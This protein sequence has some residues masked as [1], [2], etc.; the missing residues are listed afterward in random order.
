MP[1]Y[2][3]SQHDGMYPYS[4]LAM[5]GVWYGVHEVAQL[6][7][8]VQWC[9]HAVRG[10]A[11]A[12]IVRARAAVAQQHAQ[13]AAAALLLGQHLVLVDDEWQVVEQRAH[14]AAQDGRVV[15]LRI[16]QEA[17]SGNQ[18]TILIR[19][20]ALTCASILRRPMPWCESDAPKPRA[21]SDGR[22]S[23]VSRV[24]NGIVVT[25][26]VMTKLEVLPLIMVDFPPSRVD[27]HPIRGPI[28][29][30]A[31]PVS[32]SPCTVDESSAWERVPRPFR[33]DHPRRSR[34]PGALSLAAVFY[35]SASK[36]AC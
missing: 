25:L 24:R 9:A 28:C 15:S 35:R 5:Y 31:V 22:S 23:T 33:S 36:M 17:I 4:H 3:I 1:G 20:V 16:N 2:N 18:V 11:S 14:R 6:R 29:C 27:F 19:Q 26:G 13:E 7:S 21:A 32:S 12:R 10:V 8:R 30:P 34:A